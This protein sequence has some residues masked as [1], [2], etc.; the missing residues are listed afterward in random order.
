M[1]N[2]G[3]ATPWAII[4][5]TLVA[6]T[7]TYFLAG[8]VASTV[9]NYGARLAEPPLSLFMRPTSDPLVMAGV[10]I[11]PLRGLL[12][13]IVFYL[14]RE[15]LFLRANGWLAAWIMLVFVGILSTFGPTPGS[16][17]GFIYTTLPPTLQLGGMIE[18]LAQSFLLSVLTVY[19]VR[20]AGNCWLNWGLVAAFGIVLLLPALGLLATQALAQ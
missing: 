3:A 11:Q 15:R 4:W 14:F 16:I 12:F 17:E 19:W 18:I 9:F 20:H 13:G 5:R 10:L 7:L 8:I 1:T 6:H 2:S